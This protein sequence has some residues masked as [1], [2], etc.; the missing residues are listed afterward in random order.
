MKPLQLIRDAGA[1]LSFGE[2]P[3]L[4]KLADATAFSVSVSNSPVDVPT[5]QSRN[6]MRFGSNLAIT[7]RLS[8]LHIAP[9]L[10]DDFDAYDGGL[11]TWQTYETGELLP[12]VDTTVFY[13]GTKSIK[14]DTNPIPYLARSM[15]K[16]NLGYDVMQEIIFYIRVNGNSSAANDFHFITSDNN[17]K[18]L[19]GIYVSG[20][21]RSLWYWIGMNNYDTGFVFAENTW[22]RIRIVQN[23]VDKKYSLWVNDNIV[24]N[25]VDAQGDDELNKNM[26]LF[27]KVGAFPGLVCWVDK[28]TVKRSGSEDFLRNTLEEENKKFVIELKL[29]GESGSTV[30]LLLRNVSLS[31]DELPIEPGFLIDTLSF[32]AE[33]AELEVG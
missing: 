22:Y 5:I 7:G 26:I 1:T 13:S 20:V 15:M 29:K 31:A 10:A 18:L 3:A 21:N 4:T 27:Y 14:F 11:G 12:E 17:N 6:I 2:Y 8:N 24:I 16:K 28:L 9:I 19:V 32:A 23:I 25:N 33:D 30:T